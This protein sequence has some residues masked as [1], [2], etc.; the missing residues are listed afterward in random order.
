[1]DALDAFEITAH[2]QRRVGRCFKITSAH[3]VKSDIVLKW[4]KS[5]N[6]QCIDLSRKGVDSFACA[7]NGDLEC[8]EEQVEINIAN[9]AELEIDKDI[10]IADCSHQQGAGSSGQ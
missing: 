5:P 9:K 7:C 2:I 3:L 4:I 10:C 1:M 6:V 8:R